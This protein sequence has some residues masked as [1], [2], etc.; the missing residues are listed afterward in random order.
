MKTNYRFI[1]LLAAAI[2]LVMGSSE[3]RA[4]VILDQ[5][6]TTNTQCGGDC[7]G[8]TYRLII[9]DGGTNDTNFSAKLIVDASAYVPPSG[10]A[11]Y[12]FISAVDFK[13]ASNVSGASLTAAPGGKAGWNLSFNDG[14]VS[15]DCSGS[16]NG[17]VCTNDVGTNNLA[18][19]PHTPY[20][21]DFNFSLLAG[22]DNSDIAFGHLGTRY[23]DASGDCTGVIVSI[24]QPG[25]TPVPEPSTLLLVGVGLVAVSLVAKSRLRKH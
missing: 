18:P 2:C 17:F 1:G 15:A 25:T 14:Q 8:S 7:F 9:D 12:L 11:N 19:V 4:T 20:E 10:K 22:G 16:G 13:P 3:S 5:S 6:W 23:C 21:W 24:E